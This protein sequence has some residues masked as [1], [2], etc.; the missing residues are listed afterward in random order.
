MGIVFVDIRGDTLILKGETR[1]LLKSDLKDIRGTIFVCVDSH[2]P[3]RDW[4][5]FD[6]WKHHSSGCQHARTSRILVVPPLLKLD[7]ARSGGCPS[8]SSLDRD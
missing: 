1:R 6:T 8:C 4:A 2:F 5:F 3:Y 7:N